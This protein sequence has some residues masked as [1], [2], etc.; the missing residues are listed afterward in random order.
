MAASLHSEPDG[1]IRAQ[2]VVALAEAP[3]AGKAKIELLRELAVT[4]MDADVREAAER[5]LG[6]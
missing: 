2:A 3:G 5:A 4:D 1:E 6:L